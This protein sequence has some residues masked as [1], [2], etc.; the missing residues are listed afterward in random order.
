MF[1][2]S[3]SFSFSSLP[4]FFPFTAHYLSIKYIQLPLLF[5]EE[6]EHECTHIPIHNRKGKVRKEGRKN[7]EWV[8]ALSSSPQMV[9]KINGEETFCLFLLSNNISLSSLNLPCY[10]WSKLCESLFSLS[11][12]FEEGEWMTDWGSIYL[13]LSILHQRGC[14]KKKKKKKKKE[15]TWCQLISG[16][17]YPH[18]Y[19]ILESWLFWLSSLVIAVRHLHIL[20][21]SLD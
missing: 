20:S 3:V 13:H 10:T 8:S 6:G 2:I 11:L 9:H 18:E 1:S 21:L 15:A 16:S 14:G 7:F 4:V 17:S 19:F 12:P 5:Q